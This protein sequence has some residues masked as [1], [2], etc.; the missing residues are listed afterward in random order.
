MNLVSLLFT[1]VI[2]N[3]IVTLV[4]GI[5]YLLTLLHVPSPLG[6]SIIILTVVIRLIL[7]PFTS[8]QLTTA[9]KM[10][11]ITPHINALKTK[12]K[13]DNAKIQA[14]TMAL[15]KE[16]GVNPAAGCLPL[17]VQLPIIWGLYYVLQQIVKTDPKVIVSFVNHATYVPLF[18]I[19]HAWST[20]FFGLEL[21]KSPSQL[22]KT[23]GLLVFLVPVVTAVLQFIQSKMMA[24]VLEKKL[25]AVE[26][27]ARKEKSKALIKEVRKEDDF[28]TT[29]QSQSLFIFPIM[30]GFFSWTLPVGLSFYWNT[31]TI[32][33]IIQQYFVSGLGGLEHLIV[34]VVKTKKK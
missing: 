32:F 33:G 9:K 13:G 11:K 17:L 22:L 20:S 5:H 12:H 10:Q 6:F 14:E 18:A 28:M 34:K 16:H 29:F 1:D 31:F 23:L 21:G 4:A 15:Y 26:K 19:H 3:P 8:A 30:I 7:Y 24:P 27:D 25:E 2:V